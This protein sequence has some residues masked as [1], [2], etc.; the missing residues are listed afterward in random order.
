MSF[1]S[2][3]DAI[4][5]YPGLKPAELGLLV[6]F[7][8]NQ[9][10]SFIFHRTNI[11]KK[12]C[13]KKDAYYTALN[14]LRDKN[15]ITY[16]QLNEGKY[17]GLR[18]TINMSV[19]LSESGKTVSGKSESG[20][21]VHG[22]TVHGKSEYGKTV[23]GKSGHING[24]NIEGSKS[25]K[26]VNGVRED[27][28]P[29]AH[30]DTIPAPGIPVGTQTSLL[31]PD[32]PPA[33]VPAPEKKTKFTPPTVIYDLPNVS[34]SNVRKPNVRK[35]NVSSANVKKPD[36]L[37]SKKINREEENR[38]EGEN[39]QSGPSLC[40]RPDPAGNLS[41][42]PTNSPAPAPIPLPEPVPEKQSARF[43]PPTKTEVRAKLEAVLTEKGM[44]Q[45]WT[46]S[47]LQSFTDR[48]YD[49]YD[50]ANWQKNDGRKMKD[51]Q[52][53]L[54]CTWLAKREYLPEKSFP[55]PSFPG[56]PVNQQRQPP[57]SF[58]QQDLEYANRRFNDPVG[59]AIRAAV[60]ACLGMG[61]DDPCEYGLP[62]QYR[63][64]AVKLLQEERKRLSQSFNPFPAIPM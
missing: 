61:G 23:S 37:E 31:P 25:S 34:K 64:P 24:V 21:T 15:L 4:V 18:I 59:E 35:A 19:I 17:G 36:V 49:W 30:Y 11:L 40:E 50:S 46:D 60:D 10:E 14:G 2:D 63:E 57:K 43:I 41:E 16:E 29:A 1:I 12:F 7:F 51:W 5:D 58:K 22:E 45:H 56:T 32:I 54:S 26:G 28:V 6:Y 62:E 55:A 20:K 44:I 13:I 48:F 39:L 8:R 53:S 47:D 42:I 52:R 33:P 9:G 27:S 38:R 3:F